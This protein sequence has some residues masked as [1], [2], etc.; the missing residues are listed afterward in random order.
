MEG[1]GPQGKKISTTGRLLAYLKP[2]KLQLAAGL[3]SIFILSAVQVAL[4]LV[5]GRG[6]LISCSWAG[7][8]YNI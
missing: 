3:I 8:Q 1:P 2:Y 5:L 7:H 4:P 6:L